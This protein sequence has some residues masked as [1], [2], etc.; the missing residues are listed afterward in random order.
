MEVPI[1]GDIRHQEALRRKTQPAVVSNVARV[2]MKKGHSYPFVFQDGR[3]HSRRLLCARAHDIGTDSHPIC[4]PPTDD[5]TLL[6]A[7]LYGGPM[8]HQAG[9][10][11]TGRTLDVGCS[12]D[13]YMLTLSPQRHSNDFPI[14][15]KAVVCAQMRAHSHPACD[16]MSLGTVIGGLQAGFTNVQAQGHREPRCEEFGP[17]VAIV[18]E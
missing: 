1:L 17:H 4:T 16:S 12:Q 9:D 5:N 14:Q 13:M 7:D 3:A 2:S 8:G 6:V 15:K 10:V 18:D 11:W